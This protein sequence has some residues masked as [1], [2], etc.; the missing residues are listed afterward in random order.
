MFANAGS[1]VDTQKEKTGTVQALVQQLQHTC[2]IG[3]AF[4]FGNA[5]R[6][7]LNYCVHPE[8]SRQRDSVQIGMCV[9]WQ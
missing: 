3:V 7:E 6:L 4:P 1:L 9:D 8:V 2:G 5:G